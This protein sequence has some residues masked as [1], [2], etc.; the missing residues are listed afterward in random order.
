MVQSDL[1]RVS[2]HG[3]CQGAEG[4]LNSDLVDLGQVSCLEVED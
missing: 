3:S 2:L 4:P 1:R